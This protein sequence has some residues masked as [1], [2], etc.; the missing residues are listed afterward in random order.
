M[1]EPIFVRTLTE[2]EQARLKRGLRSNDGF[3]VR[4]S[5]MILASA[6]KKTAGQLAR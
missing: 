3:E 6:H 2:E 1:K 5:Q 4:R